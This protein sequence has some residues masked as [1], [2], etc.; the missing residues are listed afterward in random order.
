MHTYVWGALEYEC[1]CVFAHVCTCEMHMWQS[2]GED[3][4]YPPL[5]FI[6][7]SVSGSHIVSIVHYF[8]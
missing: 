7:F 1:V 6:I 5:F 8:C 4:S 2:K 3:S